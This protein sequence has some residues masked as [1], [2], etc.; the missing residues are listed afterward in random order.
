MYQFT[1][2]WYSASFVFELYNKRAILYPE[3]SFPISSTTPL[4]T[5]E[6][7]SQNHMTIISVFQSHDPNILVLVEGMF[8][9]ILHFVYHVIVFYLYLRKIVLQEVEGG[10]IIFKRELIWNEWFIFIFIDI[11]NN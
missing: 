1:N 7:Q 8:H 4:S 9:S 2:I 5:L 3:L 11:Y 10:G 6:Q